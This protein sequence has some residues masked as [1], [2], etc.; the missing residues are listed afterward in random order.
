MFKIEKLIPKEVLVLIERLE[1]LGYESWLVGGSVRDALLGQRSTD[2]DITT[3]ATPAEMLHS[4]S[5]NYKIIPTG[6]KYGTV[7]VLINHHINIEVTTFRSE[8]SYSDARHPD[9]VLYITDI[10]SDLSR[11]DF[12]I[13]ALAWH[14][15]RGLLDKFDG[16]SDLH[17]GVIKAVGNPARRFTE[18]PLRILRALRFSSALGFG[19][20]EATQQ[21]ADEFKDKLKLVS[22]ERLATE[23]DRLLTGKNWLEVI[24]RYKKI[25]A[26]F[27]PYIKR[28]N[29]SIIRENKSKYCECKEIITS[30]NINNDIIMIAHHIIIADLCNAADSEVKSCLMN[31]RFSSKF[32]IMTLTLY[33]LLKDVRLL[34]SLDDAG[35]LSAEFCDKTWKI[36]EKYGYRNVNMLIQFLPC[37]ADFSSEKIAT[38]RDTVFS[39]EAKGLPLKT[40]DL[41]VNG[42]DV[43]NYSGYGEG[44]I[45]GNI[46]E[47]LRVEVISGRVANDRQGQIRWLMEHYN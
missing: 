38:F 43:M 39:F 37:F 28:I 26:I 25:I 3:K 42:S 20:D 45:I 35:S 4:L 36:L 13:N 14:P 6:I 32:L 17:H 22:P 8:Y 2:F 11:R 27:V 41:F 44:K 18:D 30:N 19:L 16:I 29:E 46:L 21:A 10:E 7:T 1:E 31:L 9:A 23:W 34:L 5:T 15:V 47:E 24:V 40:S 12:T 33:S